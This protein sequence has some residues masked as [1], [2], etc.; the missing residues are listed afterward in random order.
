[1]APQQEEA[2]QQPVAAINQL[3]RTHMSQG[4]LPEAFDATTCYK[5]L[6]S[7]EIVRQVRS[8]AAGKVT[9]L[10]TLN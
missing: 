3:F 5:D 9:V 10:H 1:M 4:G 6:L 7:A 2:L 8:L